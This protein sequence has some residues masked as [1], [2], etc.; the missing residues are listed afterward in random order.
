MAKRA[1]HIETGE[2]GEE[3]AV[4]FLR[5]R[6]LEIVERNYRWSRAEVDVIAR[7]AEMLHFV[8]VK[9]RHWRDPGLAKAAVTRKKQGLIKGAAGRYME[10]NDYDGDFQFDVIVVIPDGRGQCKVVW[11]PDAFGFE[12]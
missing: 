7:S 1:K 6:G 12:N 9:T 3:A 2:R 8:E 5:R 10:D 11:T 4:D